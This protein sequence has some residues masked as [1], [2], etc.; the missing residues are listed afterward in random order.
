M[1]YRKLPVVIEAKGP[2][3]SENSEEIR[4]W[5]GA[6]ECPSV[7]ST[8]SAPIY[9]GSL[10]ISTLEGPMT[11]SIGDYIIE[12]VGGEFYPCKPDIFGRTYVPEDDDQDGEE[13]ISAESGPPVTFLS[14]LQNLINQHSI[15]N[16]SNTPDYMLAE[17]LNDCL[18]AYERIVKTRDRWWDHNPGV[19]PYR[20]G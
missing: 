16:D 6:Y 1:K 13:S 9:D 19:G 2:L 4:L 20:H 7:G 18:H 17:Y 8:D 11:A 12:G 14:D 3:T 10:I 5:C 15:E